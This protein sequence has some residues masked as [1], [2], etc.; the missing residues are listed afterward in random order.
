MYINTYILS[1]VKILETTDLHIFKIY[2]R[3]LLQ[4]SVKMII[5]AANVLRNE[6]K[7]LRKTCS[8]NRDCT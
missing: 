2:L 3:V 1:C 5:F 7:R 6:T 8:H 4:M